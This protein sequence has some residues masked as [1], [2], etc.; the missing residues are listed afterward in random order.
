MATLPT[1]RIVETRLNIGERQGVSDVLDR[2]DQLFVIDVL[3][4]LVINAER[5]KAGATILVTAMTTVAVAFCLVLVGAHRLPW[6]AYGPFLTLTP[7]ECTFFG[8]YDHCIVQ[9]TEL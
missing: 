3:L 9:Y 2:D 8:D 6:H 4:Q 7:V 1:K 5:P